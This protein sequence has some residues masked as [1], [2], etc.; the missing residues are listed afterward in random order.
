MTRYAAGCGTRPADVADAPGGARGRPIPATGSEIDTMPSSEAHDAHDLHDRS[1]P[2]D[3]ARGATAMSAMG[4]AAR[5]AVRDVVRDRRS[6]RRYRAE[7]VARRHLDAVLDAAVHAPSAHNRQPWRFAVVESER[8][9]AALARA[10]GDRLRADRLA[11]GDAPD[12]VEADAARSYARIV[13][14]PV[15][16]GVCMTLSD[17]D[18]YPD[19]R[20]AGAERLMAVQSVAMA[21]QNMMLCAHALGLASC[22]MC[23]PLFCPDAVARALGLPPD[24]EPQGLLTLGHPADAGK[25]CRRRP[26]GDVTRYLD[27]AP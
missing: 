21:A 24:W 17:M 5:G 6:V 12:A 20:R 19:E 26:V 1:D 25:P 23:A 9:R 14:A 16:V 15:V 7:A 2:H 13:G 22:W 27:R 4:E 18:D 10:M 8:T 3:D 11:D